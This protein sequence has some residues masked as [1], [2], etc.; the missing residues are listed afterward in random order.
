[1]GLIL[2]L[3]PLFLLLSPLMPMLITALMAYSGVY[4]NLKF[5]KLDWSS[6]MEAVKQSISV[7]ITWWRASWQWRCQQCCTTSC[8]RMSGA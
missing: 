3:Q 6:Q 1:M 5:P 7:L 4:I 8:L 2:R